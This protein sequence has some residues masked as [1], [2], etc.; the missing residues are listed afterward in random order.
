[1]YIEDAIHV[2][3]GNGTTGKYDISKFLSELPSSEH[4]IIT[5]DAQPLENDSEKSGV[6]GPELSI[7]IHVSGTVKYSVADQKPF[8]HIFNLLAQGNGWKIT[9][10]VYRFQDAMQYSN[11]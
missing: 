2:W 4:K 10:D 8:L 11:Y 1:M 7:L 3:N 6:Q 9:S 5:L